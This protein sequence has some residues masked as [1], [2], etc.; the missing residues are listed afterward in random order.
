[1]NENKLENISSG[2]KQQE[3]PEIL[4]SLTLDQIDCFNTIID[5]LKDQPIRID[6]F[7]IYSDSSVSLIF[8]PLSLAKL[9]EVSY[10]N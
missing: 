5:G 3:E 6:H 10:E 9:H 2:C 7:A 1:M 8:K 4:Y